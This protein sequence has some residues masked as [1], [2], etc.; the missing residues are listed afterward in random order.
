[1]KKDI[2]LYIHIPFCKSRCAYCNFTTFAGKDDQI[3]AYV[4]ALCREIELKSADF[5]NY[6]IET[7]YIGGGTPS[8]I[9]PNLIKKIMDCTKKFFSLVKGAEV[10]IECNPNSVDEKKL[11]IYLSAGINRFS[12]G[13]Q[14]FS[15]K[16]LKR[17]GRPQDSKTVFDALAAFKKNKINNFGVDFIMGLPHQTLSGFRKDIETI[18]L[19]KPAHFSC[20]F[21]SYDTKKIDLFIKDCP[22]E[23]IQIEMYNWLCKRLAKSGYKHYEVSNWARAQAQCRHNKR[24]WEQKDYLGLGPS[25]HSIIKNKMYE[26]VGDLDAYIKNPLTIADE[27]TLDAET[28]RM[29]YIMLRIRTSG[30]IDLNVYGNLGGDVNKLIKDAQTFIDS[31]HLKKRDDHLFATEK[32]FLLSESIIERLI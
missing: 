11:R 26:N 9:D 18:L 17:V 7:I 10:T 6:K 19:K 3:S 20:Y 27:G 21:L 22:S 1:M 23:D 16:T 12:L 14:S 15:N 8:Y 13:I 25:A 4:D 32:G 5:I 24:Y 28:R 29:E 31:D 30:G 2:S